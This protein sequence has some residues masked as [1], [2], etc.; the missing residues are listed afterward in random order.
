MLYRAA[1]CTTS[2]DYYVVTIKV[3]SAARQRFPAGAQLNI[4]M[5]GVP[6]GALQHFRQGAHNAIPR[7]TVHDFVRVLCCDDQGIVGSNT[8]ISGGAQLDINMRGVPP[9]TLRHFRQGAHEIAASW[10]QPGLVCGWSGGG[11]SGDGVTGWFS[12]MA[13][14]IAF[15]WRSQLTKSLYSA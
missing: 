13:T 5:R 12:R 11:I 4:N 10:C 2:S 14:M 8:E 6:P 7:S 9:D 1:P 15:L 3:L